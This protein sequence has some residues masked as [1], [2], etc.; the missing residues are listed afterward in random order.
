MLLIELL[1]LLM[2]HL[3]LRG[4][5]V[6]GSPAL[7]IAWQYSSLY[8]FLFTIAWLFV[9]LR[10]GLSAVTQCSTAGALL[11]SKTAITVVLTIGVLGPVVW[12]VVE[13]EVI[14]AVRV[15]ASGR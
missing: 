1:R 10:V 8:T 9:V 13:V 7:F 3:F 6:K 4:V 5:I 2:T 12:G 11:R 14:F 15:V